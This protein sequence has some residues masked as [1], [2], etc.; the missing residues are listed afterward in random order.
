MRVSTRIGGIAGIVAGL[1][2]RDQAVIGL[3]P[4]T[5]VFSGTLSSPEVGS[6]FAPS[7]VEQSISLHRV[8]LLSLVWLNFL[9]L[10]F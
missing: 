5:E 1:G 4:Q 7:P 9:G 10:V 6:D 8:L 3:I 2:Y